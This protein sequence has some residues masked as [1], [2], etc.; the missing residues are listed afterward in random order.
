MKKIIALLMLILF[1]LSATAAD[2][3]N[4]AFDIVLLSYDP[5]PAEPGAYVEINIKATNIGK[6]AAPDAQFE[7]V[8]E[9]PFSLDPGDTAL[10]KF[11]RVG[12]LQQ[13]VIL[14]YDVR[15]DPQALFGNT[16]LRL[17]YTTDGSNWLSKE[18]TINIK[19]SEAILAVSEISTPETL[20]P[21][22][23]ALVEIT[24]KNLAESTLKDVSLKLNLAEETATTATGIVKWDLPFIPVGSGMEKKEKFLAP[25]Q[26]KKFSFNLRTYADAESKIYKIP[27]VITYTDESDTDYTINEILG[28]VVGGEPKISVEIDENKLSSV[29]TPADITLRLVNKG[30]T[31]IKFLT[32]AVEDKSG[33]YEVV[34]TKSH[35]IGSIDSD[36]YETVTFKIKPLVKECSLDVE[37]EFK[38]A[39]NKDHKETI[40]V[41]GVECTNGNG[42]KKVG[43]TQ[44]LIVIVMVVVVGYFVRR[45]LK[46]RK[47]HG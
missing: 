10:K 24:L 14:T 6:T 46:K 42:G 5:S 34:G 45:H 22:E 32:A 16:P 43:A 47:K 4:A 41:E 37:L 33:L 26:D 30:I 15:I 28:I 31:N 13:E 19:T 36:D 11:G 44:I 35:Y 18:L 12:G 38:D 9:Y 8:E 23:T 39:N 2:P 40:P 7:L 3:T 25:G 27:V 17:R 21:G 20:V 1:S 29:N